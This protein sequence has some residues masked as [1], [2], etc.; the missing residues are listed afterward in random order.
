[1]T[2]IKLPN[3]NLKKPSKSVI[4]GKN[5]SNTDSKE[6]GICHHKGCQREIPEGEKYCSYHKQK[7]KSLLGRG[8]T[9]VAL[10]GAISVS[11]LKKYI[12]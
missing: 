6:P 9:G 11:V 1:M 5:K 4:N 7:R 12:K 3:I 2:K 10:V 8:A